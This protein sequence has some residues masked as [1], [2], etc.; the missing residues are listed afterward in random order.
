MNNLD[1]GIIPEEIEAVDKNL[2]TYKCQR[3]DRFSTE[4][5]QTFKEG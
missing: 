3:P 5:Y 1:R 4:F 2:T